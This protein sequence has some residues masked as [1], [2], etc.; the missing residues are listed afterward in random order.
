MIIIVTTAATPYIG[1]PVTFATNANAPADTTIEIQNNIS[2][3]TVSLLPTF[4]NIFPP[5]S[6]ST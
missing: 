2:P 4:L 3:N 6:L 1:F 5:P